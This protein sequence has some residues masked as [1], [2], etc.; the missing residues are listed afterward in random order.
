MPRKWERVWR[1]AFLNFLKIC[2]HTQLMVELYI[3]DIIPSATE[4]K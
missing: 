1:G 2:M 4:L 3:V